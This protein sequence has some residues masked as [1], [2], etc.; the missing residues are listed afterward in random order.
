MTTICPK[1]FRENYYV[2]INSKCVYCN[3]AVVVDLKY[4]NFKNPLVEKLQRHPIHYTIFC[5]KG[6]CD[7]PLPVGA[8]RVIG[9]E[10]IRDLTQFTIRYPLFTSKIPENILFEMIDDAIKKMD[11]YFS[12]INMSPNEIRNFVSDI[13]FD[14]N[15]KIWNIRE[16]KLKRILKT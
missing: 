8:V 9:E 4:V 3:D 16:E 13:I 1:C 10:Y 11:G 6:F 2:H 15:D 12:F 5:E 14:H 7:G